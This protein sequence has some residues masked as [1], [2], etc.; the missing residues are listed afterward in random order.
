MDELWDNFSRPNIIGR[1]KLSEEIMTRKKIKFDETYKHT[2]LSSS[3]YPKESKHE[4]NYKAH[5]NKNV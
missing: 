2:D 4:G 1:A 3:A 5:H